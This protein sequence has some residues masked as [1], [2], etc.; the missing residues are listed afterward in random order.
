MQLRIS[1]RAL[2]DIRTV[3]AWWRA[4]R[5]AAPELFDIELERAFALLEA[6]PL[7]AQ[8]ALQPAMQGVRRMILEGTRYLLYYRVRED[9]QVVDVLRV[10]HSSRRGRPK[11]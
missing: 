10:W 3:A 8:A 11:L 5:P 6:Q 1:K 4:N 2:K 9:E 7:I